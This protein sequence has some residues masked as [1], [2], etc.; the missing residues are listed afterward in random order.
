MTP[1]IEVNGQ[2]IN[3]VHALGL[4][5]NDELKMFIFNPNGE[6]DI[7]VFTVSSKEKLIWKDSSS[8]RKV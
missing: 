4:K 7:T 2:E 5:K 6:Y 8:N 1:K 3:L